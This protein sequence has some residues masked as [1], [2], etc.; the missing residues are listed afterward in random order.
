MD[1]LQIH[2]FSLIKTD[3][4]DEID[5]SFKEIKNVLKYVEMIVNYI[6][7]SAYT[8]ENTRIQFEILE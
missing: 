7:I 8:A 5:K 1:Q 6:Y 4:Y 2:S 3:H